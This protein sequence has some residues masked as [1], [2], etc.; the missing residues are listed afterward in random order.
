MEFPERVSE[1]ATSIIAQYLDDASEEKLAEINYGIAVTIANSYKILILFLLAFALGVLKYFLIA[2]ASF[3]LLRTFA[4]GVHAKREWT[5]LPISIII[6]FGIVYLGIAVD[7]NIYIIS[8]VFILC[9]II[10]LRYAPADTEEHPIASRNLR[11]KLKLMSC[12]SV[13]ILYLVSIYN[14]NTAVSVIVTISTAVESILI[15][16][17]TYKLTGNIYGTGININ[18]KEV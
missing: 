3:G 9:F 11:K 2:F 12:I 6:L 13:V 14:L 18:K 17:I 15:L 7:F 4:A 16:P 5:C 1:K 8:I 10:I